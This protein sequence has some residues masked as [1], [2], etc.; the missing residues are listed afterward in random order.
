MRAGEL[1]VRPAGSRLGYGRAARGF[2]PKDLEA[3]GAVSCWGDA[4]SHSEPRSELRCS[5]LGPRSCAPT[6]GHPGGDCLPPRQVRTGDSWGAEPR[7]LADVAI[8]GLARESGVDTWA[9]T[10]PGTGCGEPAGVG[11]EQFPGP[12][13]WD[14]GVSIDWTTEA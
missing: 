2:R 9:R 3:G 13:L 1:Q 11:A 5:G 12:G 10:G 4:G 6:P 8:G 14:I 7:L